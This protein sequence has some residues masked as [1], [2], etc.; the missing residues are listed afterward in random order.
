MSLN[1]PRLSFS[2]PVV[3]VPDGGYATTGFAKWWN[4]VCDAIE[5]NV[6][7]IDAQQLALDE[8]LGIAT[9]AAGTAAGAVT[10]AE[11]ATALASQN[12]LAPIAS[13]AVLGNATGSTAVPIASTMSAMLDR[14]VGSTQGEILFRGSAGWKILAVGTAGQKLTSGGAG[15]DVSWT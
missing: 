14:A 5:A 10:A 8:A 2:A 1:L 12:A 7:T 13:G 15:A 3:T 11:Y 6:N 9:G 4:A